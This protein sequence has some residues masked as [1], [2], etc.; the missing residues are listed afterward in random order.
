[1]AIKV[2]PTGALVEDK[3]HLKV[4]DILQHRIVMKVKTVSV[5]DFILMA[6]SG[7]VDL[8]GCD[9]VMIDESF[10]TEDKDEDGICEIVGGMV[11][12]IWMN[13]I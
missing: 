10:V 1:M 6:I 11:T 12:L 2:E 7:G 5:M 13:A 4:G 9:E 3:S 8:C